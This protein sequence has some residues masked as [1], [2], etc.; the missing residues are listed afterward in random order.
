MATSKVR[1][2]CA[3]RTCTSWT[4][5]LSYHMLIEIKKLARL[6]YEAAYNYTYLSTVQLYC[7]SEQHQT[8]WDFVEVR[9]QKVCIWARRVAVRCVFRK[10][11]CTFTGHELP[12]HW[13]WVASTW[14]PCAGSFCKT[15][16]SMFSPAK[17]RPLQCIAII[18]FFLQTE[19][20]A[21]L[22]ATS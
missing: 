20:T 8:P 10:Q 5:L 3:K 2:C 9:Y 16:T 7:H 13:W 22:R 12:Y 17:L 4:F 21:G 11:S 19:S 6:A 15:G 18:L 1:S 14:D